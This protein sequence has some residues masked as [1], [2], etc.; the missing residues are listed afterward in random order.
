MRKSDKDGNI[1]IAE[2]IW[3]YEREQMTHRFDP[4]LSH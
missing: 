2:C 4:S 3:C 1:I